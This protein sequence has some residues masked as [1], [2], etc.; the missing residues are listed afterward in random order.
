MLNTV[1]SVVC[2]IAFFNSAAT[3]S[4]RR[5]YEA[6]L[7]L[8]ADVCFC[9]CRSS[10]ADAD[11]LTSDVSACGPQELVSTW[12][13][14]VSNHSDYSR[15]L[16]ETTVWLK[17]VQSKLAYCSDLSATSQKELEAKLATVKV[18]QRRAV[19]VNR[20]ARDGHTITAPRLSMEQSIAAAVHACDGMVADSAGRAV[21]SVNRP[22]RNADSPSAAG[23]SAPVLLCLRVQV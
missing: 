23:L 12:Q 21:S 17:E 3:P 19:D 15:Q 20:C 10:R 11:S 9:A 4:R 5:A 22:A 18:R 2:S 6:G 7:S 14:Y 1:R 8:P 13:H 16:G